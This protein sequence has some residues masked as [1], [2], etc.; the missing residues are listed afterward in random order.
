MKDSK[1]DI[2]YLSAIWAPH[3]DEDSLEIVVDWNHWVSP[4]FFL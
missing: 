4:S 1:V 2:A 3:C